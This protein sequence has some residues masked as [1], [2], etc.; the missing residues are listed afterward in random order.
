MSLPKSIQHARMFLASEFD[1]VGSLLWA[2]RPTETPG[3]GT[4]GVD[5]HWR[6]YYDPDIDAKWTEPQ[7]LGVLFHEI[8]HILRN[9]MNNGRAAPFI[10]CTPI[11]PKCVKCR[12]SALRFNICGDLE[13][14]PGLLKLGF[15]LPTEGQFPKNYNLPDGLLAEDYWHKIPQNVG[16]QGQGAI[17]QGS[18]GSCAG[19]P[20]A[21]E[22]GPGAQGKDGEEGDGEGMAGISAAERELIIRDVAKKIEEAAKSRGNVPSGLDHWA[23]DYL[24]PKVPWRRELRS[25][26]HRNINEC[27]GKREYSFRRPHRR[28]GFAEIIMPTVKD[29]FPRIGLVRDTSGSMGDADM[30][31]SLAETKGIL[32]EM[33]GEIIDI[34][35]DCQVHAVKTIKRVQEVQLKGGG[36]TDMG[37]GIN[38]AATLHPRL[39]IVVVIT[40]GET[41][42]PSAAPPFKCIVVL[43]RT[44]SEN[45]V[46]PWAKT[47]VVN[48]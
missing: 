43:T 28:Q 32:T 9:H 22:L 13:I 19:N 15:Q 40:D 46:P 21:H 6:L 34:E 18:C 31:R 1:Y 8:N 25:A 14:N 26:T 17:G 36:G 20:G 33:G 3:L 24:H 45:Q 39:D 11:D 7:V 42:W 37:V 38:H 41:P 10:H 27:M 23:H 30:A 48:D 16:K 12:E 44:G 47:I 2:L 29:F 5:E 4:M 35:V